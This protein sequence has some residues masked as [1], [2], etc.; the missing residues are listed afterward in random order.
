MRYIIQFVDKS[1]KRITEEEGKAVADALAK[2]QPIIL[3][4][5]YFNPRFISAVKPIN[6]QWFNHE[7]VK[8]Q[9][10][11]SVDSF[12]PPLLSQGDE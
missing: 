6:T 5:A 10:R 1:T 12:S 8:Q 3:R 11:L 7:F 2:N 9:E 4:G